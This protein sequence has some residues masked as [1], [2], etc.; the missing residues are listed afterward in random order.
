MI[1][2][3]NNNATLGDWNGLKV[4]EWNEEEKVEEQTRRFLRRNL[5]ERERK[6]TPRLLGRGRTRTRTLIPICIC[7]SYVCKYFPQT[8]RNSVLYCTFLQ[9][10]SVYYNFSLVFEVTPRGRGKLCGLNFEY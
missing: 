7:I 1:E 3:F 4:R 6:S 10:W 9:L 8:L 2:T 5:Q